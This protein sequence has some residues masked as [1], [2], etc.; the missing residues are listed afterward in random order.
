MT[1]TQR[2]RFLA[3]AAV[4]AL[5][6]L[7][8]ALVSTGPAYAEGITRVKGVVTDNQG[9]PM[10]KVKIWFDAVDIKKRVGP[11]TTSKEGKFVI[12][13]LDISVAKKWKVSIDFPG[14]KTVKV[15]YEI[16]DSEKQERGNGDVIMGSKQEYP[17]L[18]FVLV[19]DEGRNVVDFVIAKE[20]D[21]A[22]AVQAEHKKKEGGVAGAP[23]A[24]QE[25]AGTPGTPGAPEPPKAGVEGLKK[26]KELADAGRHP[27][28]IEGYRAYLAKDPTGNPAVYFYLGKSL[29]ETGDDTGAA[30][31][32]AKGVE[33]KPDMKWAHF[34]LGNVHLRQESYKEAAQEFEKETDLQPDSDK[35]W[36][37]LG[38][39][40]SLGG[41]DDKAILAFEKASTI[42][43]TKS[44]SYMELAAIYEKRKDK[45]KA[46][47]MYQK[48]IAVDPGN[49]AS[50]FFNLGV[51]AWNE[52]RDK[53]A[54]Q[55]FR[56]A[57]EIDPK[58]AP[59][60][61]ELARTLTKLQ[62]FQ[63]AVQHYQ[64]YL[65]LNPQ[66]PDAKEIRD[67]IALLKG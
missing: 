57:I 2:R 36:F 23:A 32:F 59:A 6:A 37:Q 22:A 30:Q 28:A 65:K 52:N 56:K 10:P 1:R 19:G 50:V 64:E 46:E 11:L 4:S 55:A 51:H 17:E 14:Y 67:T 40:C 29:F 53:E 26:A 12:A 62:D 48:V 25:A 66:A 38:K 54:A 60:H 9:K 45:T 16:V 44:E 41:D 13:A 27:E 7:V 3:I 5:V 49:A 35:V 39:A 33:L 61:K 20:A 42:D 15:H 21:F 24:A 8:V 63:G 58:Y 43:P 47:E 31:A 18:Q 34:F